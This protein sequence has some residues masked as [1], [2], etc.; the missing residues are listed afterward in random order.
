MTKYPFN[1]EISLAEPDV[2]VE[3]NQ[4]DAD[5]IIWF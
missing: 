2:N 5:E 4:A 1:D 3:I